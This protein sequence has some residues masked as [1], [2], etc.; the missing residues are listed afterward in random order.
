MSRLSVDDLVEVLKSAVLLPVLRVADR[1]AALE[2]V[3][4]CVAAGLPVVELTTT[5]RG[6]PDA[7]REVRA[8]WPS[9]VVGVG[10]VLQLGQAEAAVDAGAEFLVSPAPVPDVRQ[11]VTGRL[12]LIEGGFTPAELLDATSR[13]VGKFFPA[14]VGGPRMLQ[15]VLALRAEARIV[16]TGGIALGEV[17]LWRQA[18]ALAVGVGVGLLD[19]PD[20]KSR[21]HALRSASWPAAAT[22]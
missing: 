3:E 2:Q 1:G 22:S 4:R 7:L 21:I 6:W 15:S 19:E 8:A 14:H 16:P 13:G 10:T 18:G 9:L 20:L 11:A 5:T 12:P 17:P